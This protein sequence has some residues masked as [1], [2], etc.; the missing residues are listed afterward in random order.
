[1]IEIL[2]TV[3]PSADLVALCQGIR[4][5][6][7]SIA[8]DD[9]VASAPTEPAAALAQLIKVDIQATGRMVASDAAR[10]V[11]DPT[12]TAAARGRLAEIARSIR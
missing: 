6:G 7:D 9:L 5:E 8:L 3:P 12:T 11:A 10:G 2:E 1:M 4:D